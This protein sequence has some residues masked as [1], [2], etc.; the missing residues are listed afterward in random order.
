MGE[1][2]ERVDVPRVLGSNQEAI[3]IVATK[4]SLYE[5]GWPRDKDGYTPL[6]LQTILIGDRLPC[7]ADLSI[8]DL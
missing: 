6:L 3:H 4:R 5:N 2:R 7:S 8:P 1:W